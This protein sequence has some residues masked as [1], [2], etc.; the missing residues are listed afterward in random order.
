MGS[1]GVTKSCKQ[2]TYPL[3]LLGDPKFAERA[4]GKEGGRGV[5]GPV[6]P[7][8]PEHRVSGGTF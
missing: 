8:A 5:Q 7:E 1:T 6:S 3:H 2:Y 4:W